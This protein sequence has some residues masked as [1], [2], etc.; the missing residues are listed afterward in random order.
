MW[1]CLRA[2]SGIDPLIL[3]LLSSCVLSLCPTPTEPV[4]VRTWL[5]PLPQAFPC[6]FLH[7]FFSFRTLL[8]PV[9]PPAPAPAPF[10]GSFSCRLNL[11]FR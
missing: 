1:S 11:S 9:P 7:R 2:C 6:L 5:A 10:S 8:L 4:P 3:S